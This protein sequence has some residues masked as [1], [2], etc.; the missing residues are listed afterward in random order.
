MPAPFVLVGLLLAKKAVAT[1]LYF[2]GKRYGWPR[3]YVSCVYPDVKNKTFAPST[4]L[5]CSLQRRVLEVTN[6]FTPTPQQSTVRALIKTSIKL[7]GQ[8]GTVVQNSEILRVAQRYVAAQRASGTSIGWMIGK[9]GDEVLAHPTEIASEIAKAAEADA[10]AKAA[11]TDRAHATTAG[12]AAA[13]PA[14]PAS[15]AHQAEGKPL[16]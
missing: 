6:R 7:P 13:S 12:D 4:P 14:T 5:M 9:L 1:S 10:A 2:A 15:A 11:Q 3:V 8:L 16:P